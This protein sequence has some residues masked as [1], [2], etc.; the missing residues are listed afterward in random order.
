MYVGFPLFLVF[1]F[2]IENCSQV[3][4]HLEPQPNDLDRGIYDEPRPDD[5]HICLRE[6]TRGE[7]SRICYFKFHLEDNPV[8]GSACKNCP[9]NKTDCLNPE[10]ITADS[11]LQNILTVNRRLPGPS[12]QICHGDTIIV[13]LINDV[14]HSNVTLHWQGVKHLATPWMDGVPYVTQ[15]PVF[16]NQTFQ[17]HFVP[18]EPGSYLWHSYDDDKQLRGVIGSLIVREPVTDRFRL[19]YD[20]DLPSHIILVQD[21]I[22]QI[23]EDNA[24]QSVL[25][26]QIGGIGNSQIR[27]PDA[28]LINDFSR[29]QSRL[30]WQSS[31]SIMASVYRFRVIGGTS[32]SCPFRLTVQGHKL[33][34][35]AA[36]TNIIK[37]VLVD[38][39][40]VSSGERYDVVLNAT[41]PVCSYWVLVEG[42]GDCSVIS[43]AALLRYHG[44]TLENLTLPQY[45]APAIPK[46]EDRYTL[47]PEGGECSKASL[48]QGVCISQLLSPS[49]IHLRL[50]RTPD[51]RYLVR[52]D[53]PVT[54]VAVDGPF[55]SLIL[56][57]EMPKDTTK[58]HAPLNAVLE[59]LMVNK[60]F[61]LLRCRSDP[62]ISAV[63]EVGRLTDVAPLPQDF[64]TCDGF[65][66]YSMEYLTIYT[67]VKY[68]FILF[69]VSS[70]SRCLGQQSATRSNQKKM[71][72]GD[73]KT[74]PDDIMSGKYDDMRFDDG[75]LCTRECQPNDPRL[76]YYVW[77]IEPYNTLNRACGG[78]PNVTSDCFLPQC[79]AAD[80]Y[81]KPILAVNRLLPGPSIQVCQGDTVVVDVVNQMPGRSMTIHW[82]GLHQRGTP[83]M[84]GVPFLT[85]CPIHESEVFRYRFK[86]DDCGTNFWHSHDGLQKID[87]V[88]GS[89]IVRVPDSE[90][91]IRRFYDFDLPSHVIVIQ[92]W[93]HTTA[94]ERFPGYYRYR[95]TGQSP[96]TYLINGRGNKVINKKE[97]IGNAPLSEFKVRQGYRYRFR[98]IGAS[99]LSCPYR[100]TVQ[101]HKLLAVA[102]DRNPI[103]PVYFDSVILS[104][105]ERYDVV[106]EA[107]Q[108][109]D[110]YFMFV[111]GL[112]DCD[113]TSQVAVLRY[114]GGP[115]RPSVS[116]T[117]AFP[118]NEAGYMLNVYNSACDEATLAMGRCIS[119]LS[120]LMRTPPQVLR[121]EPDIRVLFTF[122][123]YIFGNEE[124]FY[125]GSYK[126][127][128]VAPDTKHL[129]G[130]MNNI[131]YS[132]PPSPLLTQLY[133]IPPEHFCQNAECV[134]DGSENCACTQIVHVPLNSVVEFMFVHSEPPDAAMLFHPFHI[135]GTDYYVIEE[136]KL[137]DTYYTPESQAFVR[138]KMSENRYNLK[139][140]LP[141]KDTVSVQYQGYSIMRI[142]ADNPGMWFIHCHFAYHQETGMAVVL[143]QG[144][145]DDIPPP[146]KGFPKCSD[147]LEE[148][149]E[150][151]PDCK[152]PFKVKEQLLIF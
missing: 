87:G 62:D 90:N 79:V 19:L 80:G 120:S 146:P 1:A 71:M 74:Q 21:W 33:L 67:R 18:G 111:E 50:S 4:W 31:T 102:T 95:E 37:P 69:I 6:C 130:R 3:K 108:P 20:H 55:T 112:G 77:M 56:T 35:I 84:D 57:P 149:V 151:I 82:H 40:I 42:V 126:N 139:P 47:N 73:V 61:W 59:I 128:F 48:L 78:C 89:F 88:L 129:A 16:F 148:P 81:E 28:Y 137:P 85:Q 86:A 110:A 70:T 68:L 141:M 8:L 75:W 104:A 45:L 15:C 106:I 26:D 152:P 134:K 65:N 12:I 118:D 46:A 5:G 17:Y 7:K 11:Y 145:Y 41:Q 142:L 29:I 94:D 97:I 60:S 133:D 10:C 138:R 150:I 43:Q 22:H 27:I 52:I 25:R 113:Q 92:D 14:P 122:D 116:L 125:S 32:L 136:G 63:I 132:S 140:N 9:E 51:F 76:C 13:D 98:L 24:I 147:F 72:S 135:H 127:Y 131:S 105:G 115:C 36:D 114:E 39:L 96:A 107:M 117:E 119:Q 23:Q 2:L 99:C 101:D 64:P 58:I 54:A 121:P 38:S 44:C 123:F 144:E 100:F 124:L 93:M 49:A 30:P 53:S 91:P 109:I 83:W 34:V 103:E 66:P 143:W